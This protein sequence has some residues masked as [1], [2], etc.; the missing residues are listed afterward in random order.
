MEEIKF[1]YKP[2]LSQ[3]ILMIVIAATFVFLGIAMAW[4]NKKGIIFF[5]LVELSPKSATIFLWFIPLF[6]GIILLAG[7]IS[8]FRRF[9]KDLEIVIFE[10]HI[11]CPKS[12]V[13]GK[14]V[15]VNFGDVT[16]FYI[17]TLNKNKII[18]I[19]HSKG[20]LSIPNM[21][22]ENENKFDELAYILNQKIMTGK[23]FASSKKQS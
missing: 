17:E 8:L 7:I 2:K 20:K 18:V 23:T 4:T 22:L 3:A 10:N 5:G 11:L 6:F 13:S 19:I 9:Q 12:L 1:S 21:M 16:K 15:K 14:L